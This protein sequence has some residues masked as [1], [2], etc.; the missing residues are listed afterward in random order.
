MGLYSDYLEECRSKIRVG[1]ID[2][3]MIIGSMWKGD[4]QY[5]NYYKKINDYKDSR[6]STEEK[7]KIR[8]ELIEKSTELEKIKVSYL[9]AKKAILQ[10]MNKN[11]ISSLLLIDILNIL[12]EQIDRSY[13]EI[14]E[15]RHEIDKR[16]KISSIPNFTPENEDIIKSNLLKQLINC[17]I[18]YMNEGLLK[19]T[20]S[21]RKIVNDCAELIRCFKQ[22][23][24]NQQNKRVFM[25]YLEKDLK[26]R[27][28]HHRCTNCQEILYREIP[29]C[30]NCYER[31]M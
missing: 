11:I 22:E 3:C 6:L 1:E 5:G 8:D 25:Y 18:K 30:L 27:K 21:C 13:K 14:C 31:N 29:Y 4:S 15:I 12:N 26:L 20:C 17:V 24:Y 28:I 19:D 10:I 23:R 7:I 9:L 2:P 16:L